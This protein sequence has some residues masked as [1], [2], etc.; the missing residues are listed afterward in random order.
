MG[1]A[2]KN[3]LAF[4]NL[5]IVAAAAAVAAAARPGSTLHSGLEERATFVAELLAK[6]LW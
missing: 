1:G 3:H 6:R 4:E 5:K 2:R